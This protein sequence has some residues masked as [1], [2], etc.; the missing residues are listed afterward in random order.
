MQLDAARGPGGRGGEGLAQRRR[1]RARSCGPAPPWCEYEGGGL[2]H[3][4]VQGLLNR[5]HTD[6]MDEQD[7]EVLSW[8]TL[9]ALDLATV[10][11]SLI[12]PS[13]AAA[14]AGQAPGAE[15]RRTSSS[16]TNLCGRR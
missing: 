9:I 16:S 4:H 13:R 11:D 15:L 7:T 6:K 3:L 10:V 5:V 12:P 1:R 2:G 8:T 14:A